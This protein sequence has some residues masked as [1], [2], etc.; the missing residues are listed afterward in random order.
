[1]KFIALL[2]L[3]FLA[4]CGSTQ[5]STSSSSRRADPAA[6]VNVTN[7]DFQKKAKATYNKAEDHYATQNPGNVLSSE[8]AERPDTAQAAAIAQLKDPLGEMILKCYRKDFDAGFKLAE[9]LFETHQNLPTYWNQVATCHLM[10]GNERK[11]LL[12]YNKA[13]EVTPNYVP[14]LN[15]I[16]VIYGKSG[17]D[18]KALV[19]L[20]KSL[21]G[22]KFTK[23]PRYNLAF[24]LLRYGLAEEAAQHFRG[25]SEEAPQDPELRAGLA[26][27]LALMGRWGEAWDQFNQVPDA[28][29]RRS[30]VGLNMALTAQKV[31][32]TALAKNILDAT[33]ISGP[34]RDYAQE[35]RQVVGE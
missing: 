16:G 29:R 5:Q 25:L 1:M 8:S 32:Q 9:A 15:N 18:Q 3:A 13:L 4:A 19:A 22:G 35:I 34:D 17:Q 23:T 14:A 27:S 28:L 6:G 31:G 30:D 26:N 11:A 2:G 7:K 20:Q 24:L 21:A 33:E 12:F 10:Q